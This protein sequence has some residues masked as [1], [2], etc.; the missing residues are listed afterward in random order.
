VPESDYVTALEEGGLKVELVRPNADYKFLS[1]RAQS[2]ADKYGVTS[3]TVL[4]AKP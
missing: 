1:H 2:A 3:V 4:A